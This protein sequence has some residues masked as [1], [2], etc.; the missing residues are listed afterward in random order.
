MHSGNA[1]Q[2]RWWEDVRDK[3]VANLKS[4][5]PWDKQRS[6]Q[7]YMALQERMDRDRPGDIKGSPLL[8]RIGHEKRCGMTY[9]HASSVCGIPCKNGEDS[10]CPRGQHC[11]LVFSCL[12]FAQRAGCI[13]LT[14]V[15]Q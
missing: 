15:V 14:S 2:V 13:A 4:E 10:L 1:W 11:F 5:A 3:D 9:Q 6:D 8:N 12:P 7:S